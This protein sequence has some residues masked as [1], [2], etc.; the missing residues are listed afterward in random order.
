M[1]FQGIGNDRTRQ[2]GKEQ[3]EIQEEG[4]CLVGTTLLHPVGLSPRGHLNACILTAQHRAGNEVF[5]WQI[6]ALRG[7][8]F[9]RGT[10]ILPHFCV[11]HVWTSCWSSVLYSSS[12]RQAV[13]GRRTHEAK[14][15]CL[16]Q[17]TLGPSLLF[18]PSHDTWSQSNTM[19]SPLLWEQ[20]DSFWK[21]G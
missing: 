14:L 20:K 21:A 9:A 3:G 8:G 15:G 19:G 4:Y 11:V 17:Y 12:N 10:W 7:Q 1:Q 6:S 2:G 18:I 13:G 5:I 16:T